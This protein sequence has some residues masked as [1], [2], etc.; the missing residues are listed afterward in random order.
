MAAHWSASAGEPLSVKSRPEMINAAHAFSPDQREEA[1]G[2]D[3]RS[4]E[5]EEESGG[6][7]APA[8][9]GEA[10]SQEEAFGLDQ[11][12]EDDLYSAAAYLVRRSDGKVLL[13]IH[14]EELIWPASMTKLMT[15]YLGV[16]SLSPDQEITLPEEVFGP[17]YAANASLAGFLPGETT[18]AEDLL[19]GVLLPSGAEAAAGVELLVSGGSEAFV[20]EMNQT[21]R[22]LG[23]KDT[24][25]VNS[26]GLHD[27]HHLSTAA[28]L[29]RLL[30]AALDNDWFRQVFTCHSA[31]VYGSYHPQGLALQSTLW[32]RIQWEQPEGWTLLG[33]KTGFT[34]AAGQC[35][36]SLA[37]KDGEEYILIT[38]GAPGSADTDPYHIWDAYTIFSAL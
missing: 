9:Q 14:G 38:A 7:E 32:S 34:D 5:G 17:L 26:S 23:M 30:D 15:A 19:Y 1:S 25:F 4:P 12:T 37:R 11:L 33:G 10:S 2:E 35:L 6:S 22:D 13:N 18:T 16:T 28:D 24:H 20:E 36:A 27:P 8:S 3:G 21:A 29:A 31:T